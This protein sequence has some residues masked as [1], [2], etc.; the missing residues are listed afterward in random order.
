MLLQ[1]ITN[2]LIQIVYV[3]FTIYT[4]STGWDIQQATED[5]TDIRNHDPGEGVHSEG[6]RH[7]ARTS[8]HH[9]NQVLCC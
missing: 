5:D 4:G 8:V 2:L 3:I 6:V 9:R 7:M 1:L